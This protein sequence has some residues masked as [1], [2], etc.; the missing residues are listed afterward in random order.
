MSGDFS[1][2]PVCGNFR[3]SKDNCETCNSAADKVSLEDLRRVMKPTQNFD[4]PDFL[5]EEGDAAPR[6]QQ[7]PA[8]QPQQA[9]APQPQQAPAPQ[10]QQAPAPQPQQAPTNRAQAAPEAMEK[11]GPEPLHDQMQNQKRQEP[12]P[13]AAPAKKKGLLELILSWF[14]INK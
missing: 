3:S 1:L 7:G 5:K 6:P 10:P 12:E 4:K 8:P 14:G 13:Q 11:P 2:C 9:P